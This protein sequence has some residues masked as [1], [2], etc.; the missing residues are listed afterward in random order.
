MTEQFADAQALEQWLNEQGVATA[1]WGQG[2]SKT[3]AHLW[4]EWLAGEFTLALAPL[5]RQVQVVELLI[6]RGEWRLIEAE[7]EFSDGRRRMR[8]LPPSEKFKR[9]ENAITAGWRCLQEELGVSIT[10]VTAV[11]FVPPV[12]Q[13]TILSPSYPGL[14]TEYAI[15][16]LDVTIPTLPSTDFW[17]DNNVAN[18]PIRRH[19][20][21]WMPFGE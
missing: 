3:I 16:V 19:R 10:E 7:Q 6:Q 2:E 5:R 8:Q 18:D 12:K 13:R 20:W 15:H 21:A 9:S 4:Q 11:T 17:R 1:V 14:L